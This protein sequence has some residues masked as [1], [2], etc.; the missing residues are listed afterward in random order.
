MFNFRIKKNNFTK[1]LEKEWNTLKNNLLI[2]EINLD[3]YTK[4]YSNK[5]FCNNSHIQAP[6][7]Y[8]NQDD[9]KYLKVFEKEKIIAIFSLL[10][11]GFF[12]NIINI[13]R[14]NSGPLITKEFIDYKN[15]ILIYILCFIKS[16]YT[17]LISFAPSSLYSDKESFIS[18]NIAKLASPPINTYLLDLSNTKDYIY[19]NLKNNWRNGLK[20]GL[21]YTEVKKINDPQTIKKVLSDYKNYSKE[22]GFKPTSIEKCY[23][24]FQNSLRNK[25]L[26]YLKIYQAYNYNNPEKSIGSIG[27]LCFKESAIYLFGFTTKSGKKYQANVA[28]LWEAIMD[29]KNEGFK[30]F[31]LGGFNKKTPKGIIKFKQGLN[32]LLKKTLGEYFYFGIF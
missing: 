31:D 18:F 14:L 15:Y 27:I 23:E 32:G 21:K 3:E 17:R 1:I 12:F 7:Y 29:L 4:I 11:K 19:K 8:L 30:K 22:I 10:N 20:K 9:V 25:S 24:W 2:K 13:A 26:L 28:L 6:G 5:L 16:N